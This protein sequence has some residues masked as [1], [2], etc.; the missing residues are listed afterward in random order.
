MVGNQLSRLVALLVTAGGLLPH[1]H[2]SEQSGEH[3]ER[4]EPLPA[5]QRISEEDDGEEDGEE[6]PRGGDDGAR[7]RPEV[8]HHHE[9]EELTECAGQCQRR[10]M[11]EQ[12]RMLHG[13][14]EESF[15]FASQHQRRAEHQ[16]AP[17]VHRQHHVLR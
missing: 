2:V 3:E 10:K 1:K 8:R 11:P 15:S 7:K 6:L 12:L 9:D 13:E 17:V 5:G 16:R 14:R 4:P